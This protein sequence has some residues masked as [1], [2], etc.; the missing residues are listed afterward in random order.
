MVATLSDKPPF[1][2]WFSGSAT[3]FSMISVRDSEDKN[4]YYLDI[5]VVL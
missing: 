2:H 5:V 3:A 1:P 4:L